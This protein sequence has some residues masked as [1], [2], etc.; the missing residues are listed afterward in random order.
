MK[1][2]KRHLEKLILLIITVALSSMIKAYP[3]S[4]PTDKLSIFF[5]VNDSQIDSTYKTNKEALTKIKSIFN[6]SKIPFIQSV[7]IEAY[8]SPEGPLCFNRQL[9]WQR[10]IA[11]KKYII[12]KCPMIDPGIIETKGKGEN[13][14]GLR[15]LVENDQY[16]LKKTKTRMLIYSMISSDKSPYESLFKKQ[17]KQI[18]ESAW[19]YIVTKMLPKL[20]VQA[21]IT[22]CEKTDFKQPKLNIMLHLPKEQLK[23]CRLTG[24]PLLTPME[25]ATNRKRKLLMAIKTNMLFDCVSALN[26]ELEVP[27]Q[28]EWSVACEWT[29]PWWT[30]D[31]HRINSSRNRLQLLNLNGELR[32][33]LGDRDLLPPL[34]G[35]FVGAYGGFGKYDF[36]YRRKGVQGELSIEAGIGIGKSFQINRH[37][38]MEY[39]LGLGYLNSDYRRYVSKWGADKRWHPIYTHGGKYRWIGPTRLRFSLGWIIGKT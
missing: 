3:Q 12:D 20:R 27:I 31:N 14:Q 34:N 5:K 25:C 8:A 16:F 28:K 7:R 4:K 15:D 18:D 23:N 38:Y 6:K 22:I 30:V 24:R 37:L 19:R 35:W 9:S 33:W 36:E 10:A 29:F 13:W 32:Y 11:L 2:K 17:L 1:R 39:E 26:I 21:L